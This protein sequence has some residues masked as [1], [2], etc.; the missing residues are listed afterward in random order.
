VILIVEDNTDLRNFMTSFLQKEFTVI[1]AS[2][3]KDGVEQALHHIPNLILS[4][5]MMPEMDGIT[6]TGKIKTN[7]LTSHIPIILLTAKNEPESR[8]EGFKTGA[9]DYLTKPFS[10]EELRVRITNLIEQ[11]KRLAEKYRERSVVLPEASSMDEKFLK[12]IK[13][14][15]ESN[16]GDFSFSVEKMADEMHISRTQLLR[17]L[18]ALIG[19][20][21]NEFIKNL[22]LEKAAELILAKTDTIT[23]IGYTVGFNDQSYFT[24]CFKKQ[25]GVSPSEY[26]TY[27]KSSG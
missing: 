5:L 18:K 4:D 6:L 23:Q 22:R 15:V 7:E 20:A 27:G 25:F 9:D 3:G 21:P 14:I 13:T 10:T 11:R 19:L 2:N 16:L 17:K 8:L 12:K 24:K 1:T 26:I